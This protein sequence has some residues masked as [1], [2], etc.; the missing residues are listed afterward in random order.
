[1]TRLIRFR[2]QSI[3]LSAV[4]VMLIAPALDAQFVLKSKI[5]PEKKRVTHV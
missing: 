4:A 1:M 5:Q 3:L 2:T